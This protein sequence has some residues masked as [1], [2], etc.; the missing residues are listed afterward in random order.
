MKRLEKKNCIF[1]SFLPFM[2]MQWSLSFSHIVFGTRRLYQRL[3]SAWTPSPNCRG[4]ERAKSSAMMHVWLSKSNQESSSLRTETS[5]RLRAPR[6]LRRLERQQRAANQAYKSLR[7]SLLQHEFHVMIM[8]ERKADQ[9]IFP[10]ILEHQINYAPFSEPIV[11]EKL[12]LIFPFRRLFCSPWMNLSW[13]LLGQTRVFSWN[14]RGPVVA[15]LL[16]NLVLLLFLL[17]ESTL[18]PF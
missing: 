4:I 9:K 12:C 17:Y 6:L 8:Y 16:H 15:V 14:L 11:H 10:F 1:P 13:I 2:W 18:K 7:R 3:L 5:A